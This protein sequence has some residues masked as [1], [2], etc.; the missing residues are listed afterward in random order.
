MVVT[1]S[2]VCLFLE[3]IVSRLE[4]LE[5]EVL[6]SSV[7]LGVGERE[8]PVERFVNS[9]FRS[10]MAWSRQHPEQDEGLSTGGDPADVE[11]VV[12]VSVP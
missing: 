1:V 10:A 9:C 4:W 11:V 3:M 7:E 8:Q 6:F 12:T 2:I 5:T